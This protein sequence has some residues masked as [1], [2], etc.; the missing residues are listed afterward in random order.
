MERKIIYLGETMKPIHNIHKVYETLLTK[1]KI[2]IS[3]QRSYPIINNHCIVYMIDDRNLEGGYE[4][5][6]SE[7]E[8]IENYRDKKINEILL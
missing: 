2:Y 3:N 1:N 6:V 4:L 5:S 7:F 8:F